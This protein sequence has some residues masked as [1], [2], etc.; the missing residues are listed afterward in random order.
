MFA[1]STGSFDMKVAIMQKN[2]FQ[3]I[4]KNFT[5]P[6]N[7]VQFYFTVAAFINLIFISGRNYYS[8]AS[9][10]VSLN[11]K[12]HPLQGSNTDMD[13]HIHTE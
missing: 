9:K 1:S 7:N 2:F 4:L 12:N 3:Y 5:S 8:L 13:V 11:E 10:R 6:I